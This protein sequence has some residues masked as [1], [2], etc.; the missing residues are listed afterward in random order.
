MYFILKSGSLNFLEPSRPAKACNGIAL[1]LLLHVSKTICPSS[2]GTAYTTNGIFCPYY[3]GWLLS[4]LEW[5]YTHTHT[6]NIPV[7]VY[8]VPPDEQIVL[9]TCRGC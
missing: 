8:T 6:Q 2:G 1:P 7:V 5:N 3:V 4:G 9:E